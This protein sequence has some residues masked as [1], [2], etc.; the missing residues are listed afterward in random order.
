MHR[1]NMNCHRNSL[2]RRDQNKT[3]MMGVFKRLPI[4][5][6][7]KHVFIQDEEE[8]KKKR[9]K[10]IHRT[11]FT[12]MYQIPTRQRNR[13]WTK[14]RKSKEHGT[15]FECQRSIF[16]SFASLHRSLFLM[17]ILHELGGVFEYIH[18]YQTK[19][20]GKHYAHIRHKTRT[21]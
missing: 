6:K 14:A 4:C 16:I 5:I 9:K 7:W 10:E 17:C 20:K 2:E 11:I 1:T 15:K 18:Q 21:I 19:Q 13:H 8:E 12:Q 3:L